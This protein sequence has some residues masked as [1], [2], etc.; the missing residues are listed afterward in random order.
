M[1]KLQSG[2]CG[3]WAVIH[4]PKK[5]KRQAKSAVLMAGIQVERAIY[6]TNCFA[7]EKS[8]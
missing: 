3:D 5:R 4:P 8:D 6:V 2:S 1:Y 7:A